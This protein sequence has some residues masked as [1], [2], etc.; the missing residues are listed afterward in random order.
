MLEDYEGN[1]V[2]KATDVADSRDQV[3]KGHENKLYNKMAHDGA[4]D[5]AV[6]MDGDAVKYDVA[7][8]AESK[9]QLQRTSSDA[10]SAGWMDVAWPPPR[11]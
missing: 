4:Q 6:T 11:P 10:S 2:E 8:V 1:E 3:L 7:P 9:R 5:V